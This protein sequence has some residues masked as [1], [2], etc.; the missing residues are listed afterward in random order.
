M[1]KGAAQMLLRTDKTPERLCSDV[2]SPG[3]STIE[4]VKVLDK[5]NFGEITK[6]AVAAS[7]A[8][9]KELGK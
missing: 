8:R 7:F 1:M 3:G 4:G 6:S 2:C 9:T 5:K